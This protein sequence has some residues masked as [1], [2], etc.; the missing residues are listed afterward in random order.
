MQVT[1]RLIRTGVFG[2]V[3]VDSVSAL[4]PRSEL[5]RLMGDPSVGTQARLMSGGLKRIA[6]SAARHNCTVIFINQIRYKIG[7]LYGNPEVR[8]GLGPILTD[9]PHPSRFSVNVVSG[10]LG[11]ETLRKSLPEVYKVC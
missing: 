3:V 6:Q 10:G 11:I 7:V 5:E 1:D 8:S 2:V 9:A 4:I